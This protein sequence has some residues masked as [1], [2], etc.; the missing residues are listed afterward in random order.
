MLAIP[1]NGAATHSDCWMQ[2]VK[3]FVVDAVCHKSADGSLPRRCLYIAGV[4]GT[5][6]TAS[7]MEVMRDLQADASAGKLPTFQF[8]EINALRLPSAQHVYSRLVEILM[9]ACPCYGTSF[10]FNQLRV[11]CDIDVRTPH[12]ITE[13]PT[14]AAAA[15]AKNMSPQTVPSQIVWVQLVTPVPVGSG[16]DA[17]ARGATAG[18]KK[19][20]QAAR[21]ALEDLF[22]GS[23]RPPTSRLTVLLV[24]EIDMLF[25]RDQ[26]VLYNVFGWPQQPGARL[27]VIGIA[28]T[29]DLPERLLPKVA[30]CDGAC[31]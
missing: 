6:K 5:G 13:Q 31:V 8:A 26:S 19:S 1:G 22:S 25:S 9:G 29:L 3:D 18:Q 2:A 4:P 14:A 23:G 21:H 12:A 20:T 16:S 7:V 28:N 10:E 15:Q 27:V 17:T 24:D 11:T 30:R